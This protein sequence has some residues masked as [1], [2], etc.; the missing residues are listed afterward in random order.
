MKNRILLALALFTSL[1]FASELDSLWDTA[2]QTDSPDQAKAWILWLETAKQQHTSSASPHMNLAAT[3][4]E[5]KKVAE[6]VEQI[7][8]AA[9]SRTLP[10][11]SWSDLSLAN[12]IQHALVSQNSVLDSLG[13]RMSLLWNR[14]IFQVWACSV[15]WIS[16]LIL[17]RKFGPSNRTGY[18]IPYLMLLV[19]VVTTGLGLELNRR[20]IKEPLILQDPSGLVP[21]YKEAKAEDIT[22]VTEL[23]TGL[24]IFSQASK[25]GFFKVD[26]PVPGWIESKMTI[27]FPRPQF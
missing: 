16:F 5:E 21:V 25:D 15:F 2:L 17:Y 18:Q 14:D 4:W 7:L 8:L 19:A 26:E 6:A 20:F 22:K 13:F 24:L 11:N 23:P 1:T 12:E 27:N 3:Y 10:W 9:Q